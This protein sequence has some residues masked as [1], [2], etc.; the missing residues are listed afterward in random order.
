MDL[1]K[2]V[3]LNKKMKSNL[4]ILLF[5][6]ICLKAGAQISVEEVGTLPEAV[7]NN[8][9]CEGFIGDKA[10]LFSFGGIDTSKQHG[11][12]HLKSFRYN[13]ETG[14][15]IQLADLPDDMGKIAAGASRIGNIIYIAGGYHVFPNGSE[16]SSD[17]MHRYDIANNVFLSDGAPIPIPIDDQV[18]AVWRDSLIFIATGWSNS[19][20]V[21]NVQIYNPTEDSQC[22]I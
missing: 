13:I 6:C 1:V 16:V 5:C 3:Y 22:P 17:K 11:G 8:A 9:V 12:I 2:N 4:F 21:P 19:G 14:E 15:S 10:Y 7:A 20:N 18:Q